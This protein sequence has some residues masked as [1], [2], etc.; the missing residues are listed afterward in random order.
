[1]IDNKLK[2]NKSAGGFIFDGF[3]RT[4]PQ[5]EGLDQSNGRKRY[6]NYLHDAL[7][8]DEEELTKRLLLRGQTSGRPDDQ[9]EDLDPETGAGI[10]Y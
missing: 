2:E 6:R 7:E 4:V 3:P 8:V 1:M 5:A 9:N 10:Q